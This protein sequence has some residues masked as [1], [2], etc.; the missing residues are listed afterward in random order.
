M[1]FG[2][3]RK[4][5]NST[6]VEEV[7]TAVQDESSGGL[8][9]CSVREIA[10]TMDRPEITLRKIPR[11]ILHCYPYKISHVQ[12]LL[13]SDLPTRETFAL[14]SLVRREV[15]NKWPWKILWSDET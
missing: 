1:Q 4:S 7:A 6:V 10:Q 3:G 12:E 5:V 9:P 13:S 8:Q 2:R 14:E 15:N 11:N